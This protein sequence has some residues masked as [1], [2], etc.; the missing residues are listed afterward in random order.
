MDKFMDYLTKNLDLKNY[1][2]LKTKKDN[3]LIFKTNLKYTK[4]IYIEKEEDMI[5]I[6][7]DKVYDKNKINKVER[8]MI[9]NIY[10]EKEEDAKNYI[11]KNILA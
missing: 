3:Y 1:I 8:V 4:C 5:H 7:I 10:L 6:N 11:Q 2:F 9:S